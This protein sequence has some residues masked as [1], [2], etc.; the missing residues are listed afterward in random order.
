MLFIALVILFTL[1]ILGV[2][3][4]ITNYEP[5]I[6][7]PMNLFEIFLVSFFLLF[8]AAQI[9]PVLSVTIRRARDHSLKRIMQFLGLT[10]VSAVI[11]F[12]AAIVF[13]LLPLFVKGT[14]GPN[15]YG[16]DPLE[17]R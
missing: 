15:R 11:F 3:L 8:T 14:K 2:N 13:A 16:R 5:G 4:E 12:P 10:C 1:A 6:D 17:K 9:I 7:R